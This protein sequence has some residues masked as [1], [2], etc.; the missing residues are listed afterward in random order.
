VLLD[1]PSFASRVREL[2]AALEA[3]NRA[4]ADEAF[5]DC[6]AFL[7]NLVTPGVDRSKTGTQESVTP[8]QELG[9]GRAA[10]TL[11]E[12]DRGHASFARNDFRSALAA[13]RIALEKWE[14]KPSPEAPDEPRADAP[15]AEDLGLG[16]QGQ[17]GG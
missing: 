7:G 13:V 3:E 12:L 1:I 17:S 8:A 16:D 2:T 6:L 10:E 14:Q 9:L 5:R 15:N 4:L 11:D